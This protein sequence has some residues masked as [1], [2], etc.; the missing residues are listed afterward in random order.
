MPIYELA[1]GISEPRYYGRRVGL[2]LGG[3]CAGQL[4]VLLR[5]STSH[6]TGKGWDAGI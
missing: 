2:A 4:E 3:M 1:G 6:S 5:L